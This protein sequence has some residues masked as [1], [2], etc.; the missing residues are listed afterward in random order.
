MA[1]RKYKKDNSSEITKIILGFFIITVIF[2]KQIIAFIIIA[3]EIIIPIAII[4][5]IFILFNKKKVKKDFR[6]PNT[7]YEE[8]KLDIMLKNYDKENSYSYI[9]KQKPKKNNYQLGKEYEEQIGKYY[10]S[11]GYHVIYHGI[12]KGKKDQGI[13]LIA[14]KDEETLLIQCKNWKNTTIKQ[15]HLKE[16]LWNC[17]NFI[18]NNAIKT[19]HI[20]KIF[21]ISNE[22]KDYGV[23]KF[24]QEHYKSMEY[25]VIP[26]NGSPTLTTPFVNRSVQ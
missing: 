22:K 26:Y 18:K 13:D 23:T 17:D 8:K 9:P 14:T 25:K 5:F 12:I 3:L 6:N 1:R 7:I 15:R 16:F 10:E 24:M 20:R 11:I 21:I 19:L 2:Q 4:V